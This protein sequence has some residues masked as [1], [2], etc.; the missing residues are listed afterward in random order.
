M[1]E[2]IAAAHR[3]GFAKTK[4]DTVV[5][6]GINDDELADL[7]EYGCGFNAEVRFIEYMDVG[8]A[9]EWSLDIASRRFC[10][11]TCRAHLL[12]MARTQ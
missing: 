4:I 6:R 1:L 8:G 12:H 3:A 5:I 10:Q 9:T 11:R 2:G 7:I